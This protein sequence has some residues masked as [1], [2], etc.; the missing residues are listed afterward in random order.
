MEEIS[1]GDYCKFIGVGETFIVCILDIKDDVVY[2]KSGNLCAELPPKVF[3]SI[4]KKL[5]PL[6]I[7]LF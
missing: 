6:E 3:H 1:V 4:Y 5:S 7:E 2:Y